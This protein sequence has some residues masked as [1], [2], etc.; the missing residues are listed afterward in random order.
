MRTPPTAGRRPPP[1]RPHRIARAPRS[2][3]HLA[4]VD[5]LSPADLRLLLA[6]VERA[7]HAL[8]ATKRAGS[9]SA[10]C[11]A[12]AVAHVVLDR[13]LDRSRNRRRGRTG[14]PPRSRRATASVKFVEPMST[15]SPSPTIA[16]PWTMRGWNTMRRLSGLPV[17]RS[18]W[19][20]VHEVQVT[21][22]IRA[23]RRQDRDQT[24]RL[25]AAMSARCRPGRQSRP[26]RS[27]GASARPRSGPGARL[28]Q[29]DPPPVRPSLLK[30]CSR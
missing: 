23:R 20:Q 22:D 4:D 24:P 28:R 10:A 12:F 19:S 8:D 17:R 29:G 5:L 3:V 18:S 15:Q 27:S 9:G 16:L 11:A 25:T 13:V 7:E 6:A 21:A 14:R 30:E 26:S 2:T 1:R